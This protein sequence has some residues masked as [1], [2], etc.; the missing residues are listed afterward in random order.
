MVTKVGIDLGYANITLSDVVAGILREPSVALI[1]KN[2]RRII[3]VG[4]AAE[5]QNVSLGSGATLVRPF[6]NGL[7]YSADLTEEIMKNALGAL[8]G[9]E[10]I[11]CLIGVPSTLLPKQL[12]SVLEMLQR[13]G[14]DECYAVDRAA[15]ALIGAGYSPAMSVVSVNIGAAF[16]EIAVFHNGKVILSA[17]E[18]VGGEAFDEAVRQ[19]VLEEGGVNISLSVARTI[20]ERLGAVWKGKKNESIEIEGVLAL[21]GNV[22][23]M[24][25]SS[26]DLLGV[27]EKP[28]QKLIYGIANVVKKIP[29][30]YVEE[31]FTN[32][33]VLSG[34]GA[35]LYGLDRMI[36]KVLG[37]AVTR[38]T[39]PIDSV[40]MGLAR[41]NTF[42]PSKMRS[43]NKNVT[44]QLAKLYDAKQK[45]SKSKG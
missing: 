23:K 3:S 1:D 38:P 6:R 41:I 15:A 2:T 7:L 25:I 34:G 11:R 17:S 20:K 14:A 22:I 43:S 18:D 24:N 29:T 9:S 16:T 13:A 33:I 42:L 12:T 28:L 44:N 27:F 39:S 30:D 35:E 10:K 26:E 36:A 5:N 37:I 21:T 32:G 8:K 40:A 19:Y 31:I 4:N 45:K